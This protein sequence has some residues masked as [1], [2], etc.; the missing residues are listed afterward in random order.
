MEAMTA[1]T[2]LFIFEHFGPGS[3]LRQFAIDQLRYDLQNECIGDSAAFV[4]AAKVTENISLEFF[5]ACVKVDGT[6]ILSPFFHMGRYMEVLTVTE[7]EEVCYRDTELHF[8]AE[9]HQ[10]S[11]C[12]KNKGFTLQLDS[13]RA[14]SCVAA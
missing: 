13:N 3:E 6:K 9:L 8:L 12:V 14:L 4:S 5:K 7:Y 2:M 1:E 10:L 11:Q